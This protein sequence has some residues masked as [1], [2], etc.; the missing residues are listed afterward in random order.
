[1]A[2]PKTTTVDMI[3]MDMLD[4][5]EK[6][7][8]SVNE[9]IPSERCLMAEYGVSRISIRDALSRMRALGLLRISHGKK[10]V[11]E[12]ID[13]RILGRVFPVLLALDGDHNFLH[14]LQLRITL[15]NQASFSAAVNRTDEDIENLDQL[16]HEVIESSQNGM[17]EATV[18]KDYAFHIGIAHACKNPLFPL[19]LET[20]SGY[21]A[22]CQISF[23]QWDAE[24]LELLNSYHTA[25]FE[26][27]RD[28]K[29][30]AAR[31]HMEHHLRSSAGQ[32]VSDGIW[33]QV[34]RRKNVRIKGAAS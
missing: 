13:V 3:F 14:F 1:M 26:A 6:K 2:A 4:R 12:E 11:V 9:P 7:V 8:W 23:F 29:P 5:I 24:D 28:G 21:L 30:E 33:Q 25:L 31:R 17:S 10:T 22:P 20:L 18:E 27:I 34:H 15:E 19:L 32:I 16:L